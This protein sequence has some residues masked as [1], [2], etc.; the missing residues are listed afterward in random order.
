LTINANFS[1]I[2]LFLGFGS[3]ANLHVCFLSD[4]CFLLEELTP[5][6]AIM[7]KYL[8]IIT[9][10]I[11]LGSCKESNEKIENNTIPA[12]LPK[13]KTEGTD[14]NVVFYR[15]DKMILQA[16]SMEEIEKT[17][18]DH[19]L[20]NGL[21]LVRE[22]QSPPK[23]MEKMLFLMA[24]EPHLD[25]LMMDYEKK[26]DIPKLEK[27][28]VAVFK[29]IKA[30]YP[31]FKAPLVYFSVSGMGSF[32]LSTA[33]DM[34]VSRNNEI[35]VIGLDWFL[36]PEYKYPLPESVPQ[37][38]S[39]RYVAKNIPIFVAEL[40]SNYFNEFNPND[41]LMLN[42]MLVYAKTYYFTQSVIPCLPDSTTLGYTST[43]ME[44]VKNN[45]PVIWKHYLDKK[46]FFETANRIKRDY[47]DDGP[48]TLP[49][50]QDCPGGIARWT[51]LQMLKKYAYKKNL[52]LPKV[53]KLQN[54]QEV[55]NE[56]GYKGE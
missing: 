34:F 44:Y 11:F 19:P 54:A 36:G 2:F 52:D 4:L 33:T 8:G 28:I 55:L 39:K 29:N 47:V 26:I 23:E 40:M 14:L 49:I 30:F 18:K 13:P 1:F 21:Y 50:S 6:Q 45:K 51:G 9:F 5:N 41:A 31:E 38:L 43:Q 7:F 24:K 53:M 16:K 32:S 35:M 12:C 25:S 17:L 37:Y 42:D 10:I 48:F 3:K 20:Y 56:S 27:E 22:P 15:M 46:L